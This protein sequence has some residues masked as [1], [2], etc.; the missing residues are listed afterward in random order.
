MVAT[1]GNGEGAR[2]VVV[3]SAFFGACIGVDDDV[4]AV[5]WVSSLQ[6]FLVMLIELFL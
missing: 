4:V 2:N 1:S 3:L 5:M 6:E